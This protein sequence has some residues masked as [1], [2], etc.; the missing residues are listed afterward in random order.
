MRSVR[1]VICM[2][3]GYSIER[4]D[5]YDDRGLSIS[6]RF[7]VRCPHTGLVITSSATLRAARQCIIGRELGAAGMARNDDVHDDRHA[8]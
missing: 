2:M 5:A 4:L 1:S 3:L 7:E 8:A 6:I